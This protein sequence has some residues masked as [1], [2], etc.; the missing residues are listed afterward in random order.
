MT[1]KFSGED[2][3][4]KKVEIFN[5]NKVIAIH[6]VGECDMLNTVKLAVINIRSI[7]VFYAH[8]RTGLTN[9]SILYL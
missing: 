2:R 5:T 6:F 9:T 8:P 4:T 1:L 3:H 7:E